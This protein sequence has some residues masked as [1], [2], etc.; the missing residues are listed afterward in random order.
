MGR[1]KTILR[2]EFEAVL[3]RRWGPVVLQGNAIPSFA[4]RIPACSIIASGQYSNAP[5]C[6]YD[7]RVVGGIDVYRDS[8]DDPCSFNKDWYRVLDP[9]DESA[10]LVV[11]GPLKDGEH[12]LDEIPPRYEGAQVIGSS[13]EGSV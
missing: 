9:G 5:H 13:G 11:E 6:T 7:G 8:P 4:E 2:G 3:A 10:V 1:F 12:W